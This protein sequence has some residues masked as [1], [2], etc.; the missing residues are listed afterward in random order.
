M[1]KRG[2]AKSRAERFADATEMPRDVISRNPKITAYS[3]NRIIV[4]NYK[5]ILEYTSEKL[6]VKTASGI[7]SI[8]GRSLLIKAVTDCDIL[9]EG[10]FSGMGW[11]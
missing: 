9:I 6:R 8:N 7:L 2:I 4:E 10:I 1:K 3:D 11:E 5:G